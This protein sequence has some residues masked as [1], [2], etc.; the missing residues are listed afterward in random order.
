M[1]SLFISLSFFVAPAFACDDP[2][3]TNYLNLLNEFSSAQLPAKAEISGWN[4]GN[5]YLKQ[6]Q[7][8]IPAILAVY[9]IKDR[10]LRRFVL[11]VK[12]RNSSCYESPMTPQE[13]DLILQKIKDHAFAKWDPEN[14]EIRQEDGSLIQDGFDNSGNSSDSWDTYYVRKNGNAFIL[15]FISTRVDGGTARLVCEF[16]NKLEQ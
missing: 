12:K 16:H 3:A 14:M 13:K 11:I 15:K 2:K 9:D 7:D 6:S 8:Y 5:C 4:A 10:D 1:L